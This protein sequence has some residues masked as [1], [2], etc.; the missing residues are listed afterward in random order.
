MNSEVARL[1]G[2]SEDSA[3][4][5][6]ALTHPSFANERRLSKHN[7]RL[8]YLG[9]AVLELCCSEELFRHHPDADEGELTRRRAQLV[10]AEALAA[11]ARSSGVADAL[12]LG[13]G[14]EA[15]GLRDSTNVL[16]DAVEAL[17]AAAYLEAGLPAARTACRRLLAVARSRV[18]SGQEK[19]PKTSLQE[20][21]QAL[22]LGVPSY[23]L[24]ETGGPAHQRWFRVQ[25]EIGNGSKAE[26]FGRSKRAAERDAA[27]RALDE[28]LDQE[29]S[30]AQD[31]GD[32]P[33]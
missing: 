21:V 7:Q 33:S 11:F 3:L 14:A 17:V 32:G 31:S 2:L 26:G 25:V 12:R 24:L 16:A 22:G 13:R 29:Q 19:D 6:E 28:R 23:T 4:L 1:F 18:E 10:N 9:D 8:E 20:S 15:N 30:V 27:S 5:R